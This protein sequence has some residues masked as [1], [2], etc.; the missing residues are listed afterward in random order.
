MTRRELWLTAGGLFALAL[1]I[2]AIVAA[3]IPFPTPEDTAYYYG[4]ARNLVEGRGLVSDAIWSY[5]T[6][7]LVFPRPAFE[8]WLPLP[9][10][11][12]AIPMLLLGTGFHASQVG[13]VLVGSLVPVLAWRLAADLAAELRL[14]TGRTRTLAVGSGL[15]AAVSLP[16]LLHSALPDS[17]TPFTAIALGACL[18][19]ARLLRDPQGARVRDARVLGLGVL[20]GLAAL[21]RNE[22]AWLGIAWVAVAWLARSGVAGGE[23][24][25][26]RV[27]RFRLIAIPAIVGGLVLAPW[28]IRDWAV[29]GSPFPGQAVSNALSVTGF[30]IFAYAHPPTVARYLGAGLG[31][32]VGSRV[33]GFGHNLLDVLLVPSFP[34]GVVGLGALVVLPMTRGAGALRPLIVLSG[35]TFA[36][37]TL[38][39]PVSTTWGT[40]LHAAGPV[41]VLLIV[42]CLAGLDTF[43]AR[44]GRWRGWTNPVAW[45]GPTLTI[46]ASVL[47]SLSLASYG[48]QAREVAARFAALGPTLTTAGVT[49]P[50]LSAPVVTDFPIWY[51][52]ATGR[53]ALAL[54]DESPADVVGLATRFGA[55][56]L[57]LGADPRG[58]WP[59][60]LAAGGP[61]ATCF[62]AVPLD[63]IGTAALSGTRAYRIRCP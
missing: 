48:A 62:H 14:P 18:L 46:A 43:I 55:R 25:L 40:F 16:L 32:L 53:P 42:G 12:A 21:T 1:A 45:L 7:P 52:E 20:F 49:A 54:P 3:A 15:T 35:L 38:L 13:T 44:V 30:D 19:M 57:I 22:F 63:T 37:T 2:R 60:I 6:P 10:L 29:F 39:F 33:D 47:F 17:T 5:Q 56:L 8:V 41:H 59:A 24:R 51:A 58:A 34:V 27:V 36:T 11:L 50:E 23:S 9:A 26:D 31:F 28:L 4:V 61:D